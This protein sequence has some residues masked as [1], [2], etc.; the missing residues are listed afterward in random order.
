MEKWSIQE[1]YITRPARHSR[2][3]NGIYRNAKKSAVNTKS[4]CTSRVQN[5][6][7]RWK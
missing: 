3:R 6:R 1:W 2:D 4:T 5:N 7:A